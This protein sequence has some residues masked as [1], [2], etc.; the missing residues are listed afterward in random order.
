MTDTYTKDL[1]MAS[2]AEVKPAHGNSVEALAQLATWF[3]YGFTKIRELNVKAGKEAGIDELQPMIDY[4]VVGHIRELIGLS[5]STASM[6]DIFKLFALIESV[7]VFAREVH[8]ALAQ[9]NRFGTTLVTIC[10]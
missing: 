3:G 9:K 1:V 4:T 8:W 10:F 2:G 5:A 6:H 7:Q